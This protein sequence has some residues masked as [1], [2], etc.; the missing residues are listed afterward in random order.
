MDAPSPPPYRYAESR[1]SAAWYD[2]RGFLATRRMLL[3]D[4]RIALQGE[5]ALGFSPKGFARFLWI[6]MP[7]GVLAA[8]ASVNG[9]LLEQPH[10]VFDLNADAAAELRQ[11]I[12]PDPALWR[13]AGIET[14]QPD[15][16][17]AEQRE[18][19]KEAR[20]GM[21]SALIAP[22]LALENAQI[23]EDDR[24]KT[25]AAIE[26]AYAQAAESQAPIVR[27]QLALNLERRLLATEKKLRFLRRMVETGAAN[28]MGMVFTGLVVPL[29]AL[30]FAW[31]AR[32]L[33]PPGQ[34]VAQAR[35][36]MLYLLTARIT[37]WMFAL[38][39]LMVSNQIAI[40]WQLSTLATWS[41]WG[42][43][44]LSLLLGIAYF[45]CGRP[46]AEVLYAEPDRRVARKL[47][48]RM[49]W[50]FLLLQ[51]AGAV[52]GGLLAFSM[53]VYFNRMA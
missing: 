45:R 36:V 22:F 31:W 20:R 15:Q 5:S 7:F 30:A 52:W 19:A 8:L 13:E 1:L 26:A 35:E 23:S 43:V 4:P 49:L 34:H 2:L 39:A 27:L 16:I 37:P 10:Q 33:K 48:W 53:A 14:G 18:A 38:V 42:Q 12:A 44:A 6:V 25:L 9:F 28:L 32:R 21:A 3:R 41:L 29:T 46:I 47:S 40:S 17:S 24:T 11:R 50:V 51:L